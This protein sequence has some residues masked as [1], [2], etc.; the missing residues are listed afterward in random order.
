MCFL[1]PNDSAKAV[2]ERRKEKHG[3]YNEKKYL[4][5]ESKVTQQSFRDSFVKCSSIWF[6]CSCTLSWTAEKAVI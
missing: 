3:S 4:C 5:H 2:K 6:F 1:P